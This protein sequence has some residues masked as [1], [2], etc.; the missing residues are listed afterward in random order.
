MLADIN[1]GIRI[2]Q[3]NSD[4]GFAVLATPE[5][6]IPDA[7]HHLRRLRLGKMLDAGHAAIFFNTRLQGQHQVFSFQAGFVIHRL[8]QIEH[9]AGSTVSLDE[10]DAF[11]VTF[12]INLRVLPQ[13]VGRIEKVQ[14]NS[15]RLG[16]AEAR[17]RGGKRL[18]E[19]QLDIQDPALLRYR[20]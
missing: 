18:L 12:V 8:I 9:D 7:G 11:Q 13:T 19:A 20:N 6:D 10:V 4:S 14:G 5:S 1:P 17:R 16:H 15:R 3:I 2:G